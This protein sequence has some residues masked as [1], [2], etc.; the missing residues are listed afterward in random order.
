VRFEAPNRLEGI[1]PST[2]DSYSPPRAHQRQR[3]TTHHLTTMRLR[4]GCEAIGSLQP[5][6]AKRTVLVVEFT[7]W[8]CGLDDDC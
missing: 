7:L 1:E 4:R 8:M 6:L 3:T 2:A 5:R